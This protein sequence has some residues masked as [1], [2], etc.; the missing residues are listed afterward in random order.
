MECRAVSS[1]NNRTSLDELPPSMERSWTSA[2]FMPLRA[3]LMAAQVPEIPPPTTT[4]S[5]GLLTRSMVPGRT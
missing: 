2:V 4:R 3:A 5:N 1:G